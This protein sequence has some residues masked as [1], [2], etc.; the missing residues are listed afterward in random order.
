LIIFIQPFGHDFLGDEIK[1]EDIMNDNMME[2]KE[3]LVDEPL[4]D[5]DQQ[6]GLDFIDEFKDEPILNEND[7]TGQEF[8]LHKLTK[9][10]TPQCVLC[11]KYPTTSCGYST[12]LIRHHKTALHANGIYLICTCGLNYTTQNDFKKH[13]KKV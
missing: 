3:E 5:V 10:S 6:F 1:K 11:K 8:A 12:H 13:D 4:A 2:P 9:V 7:C